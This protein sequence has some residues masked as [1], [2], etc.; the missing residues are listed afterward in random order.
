MIILGLNIL[1]G[2][3]AACLIRNG[4]LLS[5]A[6]EE[7]FVRIKHASN[8]PINAVKFCLDANNINIDDVDFITF[9]TKFNYNFFSKF[10]FL[11]KNIFKFRIIAK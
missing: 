7:R 8:F 2:D 11:I 6:E 10:F 5:A 3:S 9:N 1:H 4:K